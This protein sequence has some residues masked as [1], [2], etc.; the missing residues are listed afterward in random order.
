[1]NRELPWCLPV[2][3]TLNIDPNLV[4]NNKFI[5]STFGAGIITNGILAGDKN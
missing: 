3:A 5:F 2:P 1:M 4:P